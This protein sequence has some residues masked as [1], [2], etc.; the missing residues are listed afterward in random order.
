MLIIVVLLIYVQ[1]HFA[2]SLQWSTQLEV[3]ITTIFNFS[4]ALFAAPYWYQFFSSLFL[5]VAVI[6]AIF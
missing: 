1:L 2:S 5:V 6:S 4:G 3:M